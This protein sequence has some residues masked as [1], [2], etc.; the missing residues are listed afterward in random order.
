MLI[1]RKRANSFELV[2]PHPSTMLKA[3][4][5]AAFVIWD[6]SDP[7]SL[8]GNFLIPRRTPSANPW[9]LS[10]TNNRLKSCIKPFSHHYNPNRHRF[11][12]AV[13]KSVSPPPLITTENCDT[14][15]LPTHNLHPLS[16]T[17]NRRYTRVWIR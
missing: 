8:R 14:D 5:S 3:I 13:N 10:H 16:L 11:S 15:A 6:L 4:D 9:A 1:S 12:S 17:S 7:R 2:E